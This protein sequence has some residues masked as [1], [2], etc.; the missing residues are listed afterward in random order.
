MPGRILSGVLASL[1]RKG[2]PVREE[3]A[4]PLAAYFRDNPGRLIYKWQHYFEI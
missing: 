4:N 3:G 1:F 2:N